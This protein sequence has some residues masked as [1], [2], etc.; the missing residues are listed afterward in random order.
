M[1]RKWS[2]MKSSLCTGRKCWNIVPLDSPT[3][4]LYSTIITRRTRF[5]TFKYCESMPEKQIMSV[6]S[7]K[8]FYEILEQMH[9][10]VCL[11]SKKIFA[12]VQQVPLCMPRCA[13]N[14]LFNGKFVAGQPNKVEN[15][16]INIA[17]RDP[18]KFWVSSSTSYQK[19]GSRNR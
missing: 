5:E 3:G 8:D 12:K 17:W 10:D 2:S 4:M 14:K 6:I 19:L 11:C 7:I 9:K 16:Q 1:L 15:K 13:R 18:C